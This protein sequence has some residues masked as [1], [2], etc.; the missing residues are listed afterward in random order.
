M[1]QNVRP[2]PLRLRQVEALCNRLPANHPKRVEIERERSI[3]RAGYRGELNVDYHLSFLPKNHRYTIIRDFRLKNLHHFQIDTLL[4]SPFY[5]LIIEAKNIAGHLHIDPYTKQLIQNQEISYSN[6]INQ[7][8]RQQMQL[9]EWL[10]KY[11]IKAFPI[12]YL[13]AFHEGNSMFSTSKMDKR[14]FQKVIYADQIMTKMEGLEKTFREEI[15]MDKEI[16]RIHKLIIKNHEPLIT[17]I[18]DD[19]HITFSELIKGAQCPECYFL[20]M[21]R[22][23]GSW[24]CM[25]C[26]HSSKTAHI[27]AVEEFLLLNHC[28]TNQQCREFLDLTSIHIAYQLLK[29]MNLQTVGKY[30]DRTY[31]FTV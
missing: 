7:A 26:Q 31:Y 18:L 17:N 10:N 20:P 24:K 13:V 5:S 8:I 3:R 30:K 12:D 28:I 4:I 19:Y 2:K 22:I 15:L 11:K 1:T 16:R 23:S 27:R 9:K 25:K 29:N 6:P 21:K 14:V